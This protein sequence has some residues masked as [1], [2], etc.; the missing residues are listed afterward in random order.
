MI[1]I[2]IPEKHDALGFLALAKSG[3]PVSCLAKNS[4][5]VVKEHLT[6]LRRK[7][8][9][10]KRLPIRSIRLPKPSRPLNEEV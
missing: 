1:Y 4:Y 6:I 10:F 5:G 9:P 7:R 3:L 2:Q 8:I